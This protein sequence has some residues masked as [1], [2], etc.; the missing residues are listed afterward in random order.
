MKASMLMAAGGREEFLHEDIISELRRQV[1]CMAGSD[2][3]TG[4]N[5]R[6]CTPAAFA[7]MAEELVMVWSMKLMPIAASYPWLRP[8]PGILP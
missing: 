5:M 3:V 4:I 1:A 8:G 2:V 6:G 7:R